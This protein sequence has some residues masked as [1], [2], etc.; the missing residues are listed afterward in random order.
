MGALVQQLTSATRLHSNRVLPPANASRCSRPIAMT[1]NNSPP[2]FSKCVCVC[3]SVLRACSVFARR[4]QQLSFVFA[5]DEVMV[6]TTKQ[7]SLVADPL[8][9]NVTVLTKSTLTDT[10]YRQHV[11]VDHTSSSSIT[12]QNPYRRQY[13]CWAPSVSAH[14]L[15]RTSQQLHEANR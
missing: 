4:R 8:Q 1:N 14:T 10:L 7:N 11:Y 3:V 6:R 2:I 13:T 9:P 12:P 5:E 15:R